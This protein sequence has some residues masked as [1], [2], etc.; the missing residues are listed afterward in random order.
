VAGDVW[1]RSWADDWPVTLVDWADACQFA[2]RAGWRLP[3]DHEWEKAAR[4]ADGR[5]YAWGDAFDPTRANMALSRPTSPGHA[6]VEAF[7]LDDSPYGVRGM[8]GNVRDWCS[9]GYLR[10]GPAG[11]LID[12]REGPP[13]AE[14]RMI[15]GGSW[16]STAMMCRLATRLVSAPTGRLTAV[17]FRLARSLG[18]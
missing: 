9:N 5:I 10:A 13:D 8:T 6:P 17:G 15:R 4:G 2:E 18:P 3:H 16:S 1:H 14:Y 12:P 7:P 11:A